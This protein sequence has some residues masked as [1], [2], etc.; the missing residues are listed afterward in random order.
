[1]GPRPRAASYLTD[2]AARAF[3][4]HIL[5]LGAL[6][7][8]SLLLRLWGIKQG[9]P[10][11]YN[12]DEAT[13]FVPIAVGFFGHGLDPHYFLNPPGYTY[14]LYAVFR[15]WFGGTEAVRSAYATDPTAV[16]VLARVMAALLSTAAVWLTYLAGSRFFDRGGPPATGLLAAAILGLAFLPVFYSHVALNDAPTLAPVA[17]A[18]YGSAGVLRRGRTRDYVL[19]G[20]GI[21]LAAATKYTGGITLLCLLGAFAADAAERGSRPAL[22]R[23]AL[24]LLFALGG[25]LLAN[26]Y[27]VLDSRSFFS[28]LSQQ[29]TLAGGGGAPAKLGLSRESGLAY[30]LW[31]FTW[32]MG[33]VPALAGLGG[34]V[35]LVISRRAAVALTLLAG[36]LAFLIFMGLQARFFGR[37]L[38]PIFPIVAILGGYAVAE[39]VRWAGRGRRVPTL[40]A[41]GV[42][43][44]VL[45]AQSL[46]TDIHNDAVLS[47]PDTRNLARAWMVRHIPAGSKVV[48]EP[49]VPDNWVQYSRSRGSPGPAADRW[50]RYPTWETSLN[51]R[52][53]P[54]RSARSRP[55]TV[56]EYERALFPSLIAGYVTRGYCWVLTGSLQSGRAYVQP[57]AAPGAISYYAALARTSTLAYQVSPYASAARPVPFNFDWSIDYYPTEYRLPGPQIKIYR[58]RGGRCA[59]R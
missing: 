2:R 47:R 26:P 25:F 51:S 40:L 57:S 32:G 12:I 43:V 59:G 28:G 50:V 36:P 34:A 49:I 41:G 30:Y 19:A 44:V 15:L 52:G 7:A 11:S 42:A 37:W 3:R 38:M 24:A 14:L 54:L 27:A 6:L 39:A 5:A 45:L 35:L 48:I 33:W 22:R 17:L 46:V 20:T 9:L 13:H 23:L 16:F 31:T 53:R 58:L 18:L 21:G 10:Y 56:E 8:V 55:V 4:P 1:M 29:A